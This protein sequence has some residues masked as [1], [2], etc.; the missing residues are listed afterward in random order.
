MAGHVKSCKKKLCVDLRA[1]WVSLGQC[2]FDSFHRGIALDSHSGLLT[3]ITH[4]QALMNSQVTPSRSPP[5]L[6]RWM[7]FFHSMTYNDLICGFRLGSSKLSR[8]NA[9]PNSAVQPQYLEPLHFFETSWS[10]LFAASQPEESLV[11]G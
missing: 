5:H 9:Q 8:T 6:I 10:D 7:V 4:T 11:S 2:L 1:V 3:V